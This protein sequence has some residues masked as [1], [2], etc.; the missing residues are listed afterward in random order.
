MPGLTNKKTYQHIFRMN[1]KSS[2]ILS[3][4]LW[5]PVSII[6]LRYYLRFIYRISFGFQFSFISYFPISD[7]FKRHLLIIC[8]NRLQALV[9]AGSNSSLAWAKA[10]RKQV[11]ITLSH[12]E[13]HWRKQA[14]GL[15]HALE[16]SELSYIFYG[17][18]DLGWTRMMLEW[19]SHGWHGAC[20]GEHDGLNELLNGLSH[21]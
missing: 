11:L 8:S 4:I 10:G 15:N 13:R 12:S 2:E 6:Y 18:E 17:S 9:K 20:M 21:R 19:T 14:N 16:I 7:S 3:E 5:N 1:L